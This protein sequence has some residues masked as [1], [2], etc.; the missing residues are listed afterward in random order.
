MKCVF[1]AAAA[2]LAACAPGLSRPMIIGGDDAR[3]EEFRY[4]VRIEAVLK[5]GT[6]VCAGSVIGRMWVLT[7]AHCL[8]NQDIQG[9]T[10]T[11]PPV[12]SF[13][14][15]VFGGSATAA[16]QTSSS[17]R[18]VF[19]HPNYRLIPVQ[20]NDIAILELREPLPLMRPIGL[21]EAGAA[22]PASMLVAGWGDT[23]SPSGS[24]SPTLKKVTLATVSAATCNKPEAY[25]GQITTNN[26][27][28]GPAGGG[29][30]TCHGDSGG[31]VTTT[32]GDPARRVQVGIVSWAGDGDTCVQANKYDVFTRVSAYRAWIDG[33]ITPQPPPAAGDRYTVTELGQGLQPK[34]INASG[35][36]TGWD[37]GGVFI[38]EANGANKRR[39]PLPLAHPEGPINPALSEVYGI[40]DAGRVLVRAKGG[41]GRATGYAFSYVTGPDGAEPA[42]DL[43]KVY[44][45]G[46]PDGISMDGRIFGSIGGLNAFV[47]QPSVGAPQDLGSMP[48]SWS[49]QA[50]AANSRGQVAGV[51]NFRGPYDPMQIFVTGPNGAG[52]R[53]LGRGSANGINERGQ[54]I[55]KFY[56]DRSQPGQAFVTGNDGQGL[57]A[58]GACGRPGAESV[59]RYINAFGVV[60]GECSSVMAISAGDGASR[61]FVEFSTRVDT[62]NWDRFSLNGINDRGQIVGT[63]RRNDKSYGVLFEPAR[64]YAP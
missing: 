6:T 25:N 2:L 37:S 51:G 42:T 29:K 41:G 61:R 39:L 63:A 14:V 28:A 34:A 9:T 47:T 57:V 16:D 62:P 48:N 44:Q 52:M 11:Y 13:K 12:A 50:T 53:N 55:G 40:S 18:H 15:N 54:V 10:V 45:T 21:P 4:Q 60:I 20:D 27:C 24:N 43:S 32:D 49:T 26:I 17:V 36:V 33:I 7:A 56:P 22:A 38:M 19:V 64:L 1:A 59:A 23:S 5:D 31:P 46:S 3:F 58:L 35:Q 30:G 8:T